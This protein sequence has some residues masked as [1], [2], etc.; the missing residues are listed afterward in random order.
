MDPVIPNQPGESKSNIPGVMPDKIFSIKRVWIIIVLLITGILFI[1][2]PF[3]FFS[4]SDQKNISASSTGQ[5]KIST[6]TK[7]PVSITLGSTPAL[8]TYQNQSYTVR[9]PENWAD[10]TRNYTSEPGKLF[11]ISPSTQTSQNAK[12]AIEI[13]D[14]QTASIA[15]MSA[16]FAFLGF[17]KENAIVANT[18][19]QRFQGSIV[20]NQ[21][22]LHNTIYLFQWNNKIYLI[23]L[24]YSGPKADGSLEK[25][26]TTMVDSLTL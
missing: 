9:Y 16:G 20:L 18:A 5:I 2:L 15:S 26:F 19:V 14:P 23:K 13:M 4:R 6:K 22:T 11:V 25:D 21:K 8:Q 3:Y 17:K 12:I 10:T 1:I 24:S 7:I